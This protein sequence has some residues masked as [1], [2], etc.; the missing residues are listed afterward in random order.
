MGVQEAG[1]AP[2][3]VRS[4]AD[5]ARRF[6]PRA[7]RYYSDGSGLVGFHT[8]PLNGG[9]PIVWYAP[10]DAAGEWVQTGSTL[11]SEGAAKVCF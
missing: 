9:Q 2:T 10:G 11:T 3:A 6:W 7:R 5:L 8:G 4:M 1:A